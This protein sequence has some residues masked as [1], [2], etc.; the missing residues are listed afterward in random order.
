MHVEY[1]LLSVGVI[2]LI[3]GSITDIKKREVADSVNY[4]LI[5]SGLGLRLI[6]SLDSENWS[7]FLYGLLG[8]GVFLALAYAM[9]LTGQWG[10]GDSKMLMAM[11]ALFATYP[12]FLYAYFEPQLFGLPL[13]L[14]F[15]MNLLLV[16]AVYGLL[17]TLGIGLFHLSDLRSSWKK[18]MSHP[19]IRKVMLLTH[20]FALVVLI[21]G[22][23]AYR[24]TEMGY[25]MVLALAFSVMVLGFFYLFILV[26]SVENACMYRLV[27]PDQLVEGDWPF[28]DIKVEGKVV[29]ST[30][31]R[32]GLET[33]DIAMLRRFQKQD[34]IDKIKVK[35]GVP[36]VP[37]F[38]LS[39]IVT[40][41]YGNLML[42]LII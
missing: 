35:H 37:S 20:V 1:I 28:D 10:G 18:W 2:G 33:K 42:M 22:F 31:K 19:S 17:W 12:T 3:I 23:L 4:F 40:F 16:G 15:W 14:A 7:F 6:H 5:F 21:V 39:L 41:S 8:F 30:D 29:F 9:F 13:L 26:K 11:G 24:F 34:K 25:A 38:L 32:I 36:F 27:R